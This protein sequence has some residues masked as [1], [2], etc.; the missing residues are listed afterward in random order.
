[1]GV[2]YFFYIFSMSDLHPK[3]IFILCFACHVI[4]VMLLF[5]AVLAFVLAWWLFPSQKSVKHQIINHDNPLLILCL[6]FY[7][8]NVSKR[9]IKTNKKKKKKKKKEGK[10]TT[11]KIWLILKIKKCSILVS[12]WHQCGIQSS[13]VNS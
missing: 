1:M 4:D 3:F 13:C 6:F 8:I 10:I 11:Q 2:E 9:K 7:I 12:I 5:I